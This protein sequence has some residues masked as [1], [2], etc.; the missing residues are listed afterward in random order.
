MHPMTRS[1]SRSRRGF[2]LV[3]LLAVV[4]ILGLLTTTLVVAVRGTFGKAKSE[5]A[6]TRIGVIVNA[7]ETYAL[8]QGRL[9]TMDEG[10]EILAEKPVGRSDGYIKRSQLRDP[11]GNV[12][13]YRVPGRYG[14]YEVYTY[15]RDGLE[16]GDGEDM[17][18]SSEDEE[19]EAQGF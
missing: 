10:L 5:L 11:W 18:V 16:G 4:V 6:K 14:E 15:G 2:T 1:R 13:L 12:F 17:D 7:I 19:A 8:E 3:E 9:P